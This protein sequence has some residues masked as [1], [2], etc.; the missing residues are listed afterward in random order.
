MNRLAIFIVSIV[1]LVIILVIGLINTNILHISEALHIVIT[2]LLFLLIFGVFK[3]VLIP[4]KTKKE[5]K[6]IYW[7]ALLLTIFLLLLYIV[8]NLV[9]PSNSV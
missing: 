8:K 9:L 2:V 1:L 5:G 7:I 6:A 3:S 4:S